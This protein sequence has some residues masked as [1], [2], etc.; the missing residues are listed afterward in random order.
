MLDVFL[1]FFFL[2]LL[3]GIAFLDFLYARICN[4]MILGLVMVGFLY[5][6]VVQGFSGL[7]QSLLG[8][9]LGLAL[10]IVPYAMGGMAAGDVKL[11]GAVGAFLGPGGVFIAFLYS[12]IAGGLYALALIVAGRSGGFPRRMWE[13][14]KTFYL[15]RKFDFQKPTQAD[16]SP[17]IKYGVAIAAG[18]IFYLILEMTGTGQIVKFG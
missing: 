17:K 12:A 9:L 14:V 1:K 2:C 10:L 15:L 16:N 18:T 11:M 13:T 4:K 6:L 7:L 8:I 3:F 5:M